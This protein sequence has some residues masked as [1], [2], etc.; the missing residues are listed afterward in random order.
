MNG[1]LATFDFSKSEKRN[2][3]NLLPHSPKTLLINQT[4]KLQMLQLLGFIINEIRNSI[5]LF[6]YQKKFSKFDPHI[7]DTLCQIRAYK[8]LLLFYQSTSDIHEQF[9]KFNQAY[10]LVNQHIA[11]LEALIEQ[12]NGKYQKALDSSEELFSFM[13]QRGLIFNISED[14]IFLTQAK[15]VANFS[16]IDTAGVSRGIDYDKLC[17]KAGTSKSLAKRIIHSYQQHIATLSCSFIIE[18]LEELPSLK[19]LKRKLIELRQIDNDKRPVLPCYEATKVLLKHILREKHPVILSVDREFETNIDTI[20]LLFISNQDSTRFIL[21]SDIWAYPAD[22]PC[23]IIKGTTIYTHKETIETKEQ[24][25]NR[26]TTLGLDNAILANM[27]KHPQYSAPELKDLSEDPYQCLLG[28]K[29]S[30]LDANLIIDKLK[31]EF[32]KMKELSD[33]TGCCLENPSLFLVKHIFCDM[34]GNYINYF[35]YT[36]PHLQLGKK[37]NHFISKQAVI[38][39]V[40]HAI[41]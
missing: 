22:T 30:T 32:I 25:I 26:L 9:E 16:K 1:N 6:Y 3:L 23:I 7:G 41:A 20:N 39:Q 37:A 13:Q 24:F 19:E 28:K 18:L 33:Q 35:D 40:E 4:M 29:F 2:I 8:V 15:I 21:N 12:K 27:A 10:Q 34:A 31:N 17:L 38:E 11:D 36:L 14:L 5:V